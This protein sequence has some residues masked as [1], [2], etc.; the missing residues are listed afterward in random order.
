[1]NCIQFVATTWTELNDKKKM[2]IREDEASCQ[3]DNKPQWQFNL[4]RIS[5]SR[6]EILDQNKQAT[7]S[8]KQSLII[9]SISSNSSDNNFSSNHSNDGSNHGILFND[10]DFDVNRSL[11]DQINSIRTKLNEIKCLNETNND[12]TVSKIDM[13]ILKAN[14]SKVS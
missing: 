6:A 8:K 10:V 1:M 3:A 5:S 4:R 14:K 12:P 11:I 2:N 7:L 9:R 13:N